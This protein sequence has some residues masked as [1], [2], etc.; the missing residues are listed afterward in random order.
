MEGSGSIRARVLVAGIY[1]YMYYLEI[2]SMHFEQQ[3]Q[4]LPE[5]VPL[6]AQ[7]TLA[8]NNLLPRSTP[9]SLILAPTLPVGHSLS[10]CCLPKLTFDRHWLDSAAPLAGI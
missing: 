9:G 8:R 6:P 10:A 5:G 4:L 1:I 3:R 7:D 2:P